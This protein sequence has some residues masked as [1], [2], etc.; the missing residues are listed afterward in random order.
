MSEQDQLTEEQEIYKENI[1]D[2]YKNPHNKCKLKNSTHTEK[3]IN[4]MCGDHIVI[5]LH[6]TND[7]I[8]DVSFEGDGCAI[9]QASISL[10]T[11]AIKGKK[12]TDA[13]K[14]TESDIYELLGIP[15][16]HTRRKCALLSLTTLKKALE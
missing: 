10:L 1:I 6:V 15:I 11:D 13:L 5:Y 7:T 14:L 3:G 12:V 8:T 4:P 2:H 9:S 16:S